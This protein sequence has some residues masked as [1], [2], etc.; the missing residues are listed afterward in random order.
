MVDS[1]LIYW[2]TV[3]DDLKGI[4]IVVGILSFLALLVCIFL[5]GIILAYEYEDK[6]FAYSK[7][8]KTLCKRLVIGFLI[9][10]I[11]CVI[12]ATF[13]PDKETISA[14][15]NPTVHNLEKLKDD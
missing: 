6:D 1:K 7:D 9:T 10:F 5:F 4:F 8:T 2:A 15:A 3:L 12:G 14:M 13:I 11:I